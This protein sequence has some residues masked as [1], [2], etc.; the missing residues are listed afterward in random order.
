MTATTALPFQV[1]PAPP[2]HLDFSDA[3]SPCSDLVSVS[4]GFWDLLKHSIFDDAAK[5]AEVKNGRDAHEATMA[6]D[7]FR[8]MPVER[9]AWFERHIRELLIHVAEAWPEEGGKRPK[10]LL[11]ALPLRSR[12]RFADA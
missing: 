7:T 1:R 10:I 11:R 12:H 8:T 2:H 4:T 5:E 3:S 9:R 6:W